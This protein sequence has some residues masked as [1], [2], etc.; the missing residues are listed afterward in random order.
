MKSPKFKNELLP[1]R[2]DETLQ[3]KP[4]ELVKDNQDL[5]LDMVAQI[6]KGRQERLSGQS[7]EYTFGEI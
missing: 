4:M 7:S 6:L 2:S 5:P 1:T 3:E